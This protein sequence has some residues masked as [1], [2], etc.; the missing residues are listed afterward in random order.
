MPWASE[1]ETGTYPL[2]ISTSLAIQGAMGTHPDRPAGKYLLGDFNNLR[3]NL[4]SLFKN[5]YEAI[6]KDN[7]P[8]ID[9]GDLINSF[10]QE[11][12][13][14]RDI[15]KSESGGK[16]QPE[17][18]VCDYLGL[19]Q[20]MPH[21]MLRTDS[22]APQQLYAKTLK[23]VLGEILKQDK[24]IAKIHKLKIEEPEKVTGK[25]L[26]HTHLPYDL[27]SKSFD[28]MMLL[29]S[30]TGA[31]KDKSMWYTKYYRGQEL[32][33]IPF[34]EDMLAI[35]GDSYM[36]SPLSQVYRKTLMELAAKYGWHFATTRAMIVY[37]LESLKDK[38][39]GEK[40]KQYLL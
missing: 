38:H 27:F 26:I 8:L 11:L 4:K 24:D 36:F 15:V 6:G 12:T 20:R 23:L 16:I 13:T 31:I 25:T 3:A 10:Y 2:S 39:L 17:F 18:Y 35:F 5:Y 29:E 9:A 37:G 28:N 14:Y 7:V 33:Q 21:A 22:T 34:R 19:K 40:L 1:R 30:H 32:V